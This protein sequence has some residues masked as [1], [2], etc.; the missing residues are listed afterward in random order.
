VEELGAIFQSAITLLPPDA[1]AKLF[2]KL[3]ISKEIEA[4]PA[5]A[6]LM[7]M[8]VLE[9]LGFLRYV[10]EFIGEEHTSIEQLKEYYQRKKPNDKPMVPSTGIVLSLI[11]ADMIA[12]P[13]R[14]TRAYK[15]EEMAVV[16]QTGPLL[17]IEPNLLNDDRIGKALDLLGIIPQ[18]MK[19]ILEVMVID[20]GKRDNIALNRFILDTSLLQLDGEFNNAPKV[21][22]GRGKDSF[23]QLVTSLVIASGSRMPVSFGVLPGNTSDSKTLPDAY[24]TIH[25]IADEGAIEILFDRA[26]PT[27]SNIRF[28]KDHEHERMVYWIGP[29]KIGLSEQKVREL[30]QAALDQGLWQPITYRST[31]EIRKNIESP[32]T[33]FESPWT[34]REVIKPDLEPGQKRRPKGSIQN[35]EIDVR[36]V[37]YR[38][39]VNAASEKQRR[40]ADKA[41]LD[42]ELKELTLKLNQRKYR[43]LDYCQKKLDELLKEYPT[44]KKFVKCT[45]CKNEKGVISLDW[46]WDESAM[47]AEEKFDG[48]FALLTNHEKEH[49]NQNSLIKKYRSRDQVE[50]DFKDFKGILDLER[51]VYQLPQRIDA[52]IFLKVVAYFVLAF[53]RV[54][55]EKAGAKTTEKNIQESMGDMLLVEG[56]ILPLGIKT[57]SV[58]RDTKLNKLLRSTFD[59]PEPTEL[60]KI[61]NEAVL[62]QIDTSILNWYKSVCDNGRDS[63]GSKS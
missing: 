35:I 12:C 40:L 15:F 20:A 16:W 38:H 61:L 37:F 24:S 36:C 51:I 21:C 5:G 31:K 50:V 14:I 48:I 32:L 17:G 9:H 25:K 39:E 59:L 11:V 28:L 29:L 22:P 53:L 34:L 60:I 55:A 4:A 57:Y 1:Q 8:Y 26:Y 52:H 6:I 10:D 3:A 56:E 19:E 7:G 2:P 13:R 42:E 43:N 41:E 23:S 44:T 18:T 58:A 63:P 46:S 27:A 47:S 33:A 30:I 45:L 49:V 62:Q 54:Y